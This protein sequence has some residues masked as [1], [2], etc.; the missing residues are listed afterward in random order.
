LDQIDLNPYRWTK[1]VIKSHAVCEYI[2]VFTRWQHPAVGLDISIAG[3]DAARTPFS[4]LLAIVCRSQ[5]YE[6]STSPRTPATFL[7]LKPQT[8]VK[9]HLIQSVHFNPSD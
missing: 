3:V 7:S 2:V 1:S 5:C 6:H 4:A 9:H 8:W